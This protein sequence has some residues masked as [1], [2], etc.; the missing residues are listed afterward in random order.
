MQIKYTNQY[1]RI[2]KVW[3]SYYRGSWEADLVSEFPG[4]HSGPSTSEDA[5]DVP[6]PS[7]PLA[8][9]Q[10]PDL[11]A[12]PPMLHESHLP[13]TTL[14]HDPHV[15]VCGLGHVPEGGL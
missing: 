8:R 1:Q 7:S 6:L 11:L 5:P 2:D 14:A 15:A 4:H 9:S 10:V 3:G 12:V 13:V